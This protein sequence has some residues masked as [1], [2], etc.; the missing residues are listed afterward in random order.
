MRSCSINLL[1]KQATNTKLEPGDFLTQS[2]LIE[3]VLPQAAQL[4]NHLL[5]PSTTYSRR[6]SSLSNLIQETPLVKE[7]R[8]R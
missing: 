4:G 7:S 1:N 2:E 5:L 8:K 6:C 3:P